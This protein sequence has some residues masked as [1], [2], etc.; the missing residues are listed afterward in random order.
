MASLQARHTRACA[1]GDTYRAADHA[2]GCT[3][4]PR[5]VCAAPIGLAWVPCHLCATG[6]RRTARPSE[7][8][9]IGNPK[10]VIARSRL[11]NGSRERGISVRRVLSLMSVLA[12]VAL[13]L[14]GGPASADVHGVSQAGCAPDG[15]A[16]G[17]ISSRGAP[18]RP[19][20][21]IPVTASGGRTQGEGGDAP[22]QGQNC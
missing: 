21:P 2:D 11:W 14:P 7:S 3:C 19:D 18:G 22:A 6:L 9:L 13:G 5:E 10:P 8:D 16:S 4:N 15:V 1:L 20:A 12:V 17:A